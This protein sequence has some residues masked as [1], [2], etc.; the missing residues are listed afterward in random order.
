MKAFYEDYSSLGQFSHTDLAYI[1]HDPKL[2]EFFAYKPSKESISEA[3]EMRKKFAADRGLLLKVLK[4]QY[5]NLQLQLPVK[6]DVILNENTFTVVTSHQPT[7]LTGAL[8]HIYK[9]ASVIHLCQNLNKENPGQK[10]LPVFIMSGE[11]HDWPEVNHFHL[12]GRRY[13]WNRNASGPCGRLSLEGLNEVIESV[14]ELFNNV[15]FAEEIKTKLSESLTKAKNYGEF[16]SL[17]VASLFAEF[18]LIVLNLDDKELKEAFIP[19]FEKEIKE[20]FSHHHVTKTQSR[21]EQKGFKIQAF[22]RPVNMFY[23]TDEVRERLDPIEDGLIRVGSGV[24]YT[25]DEIITELHAHPERFSPNVILRPLYQ[26]FILPNIAYVGGG[27][28][29]AYW[30][31]RKDQ[32]SEA[33][34]HYPILIRRNSLLTID[35]ATKNQLNKLGLESKDM[36]ANLDVINRNFL[37]KHSKN[38]LTYETELKL[39]QDAYNELAAKAEKIDP[40]LSKAIMAEENKQI[41]LFEQ[42]GSRLERAEKQQQDTQIKKVQ[43]LKEKLFPENGL[44]ERHENFLSFYANEGPEWIKG[45]IE[46]CDPWIEKF[47]LVESVE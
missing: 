32:F 12:F 45:I 33:K 17:L 28:E 43:K 3:L 10:F 47:I 40:T 5:S 41:K 31:E 7:L 38:E 24:K 25:M 36:L 42:L 15:P 1:N 26:E 21:L 39:I 2:E 27:G 4:K 6:D 20:R 44:Q 29:L 23:M 30:L 13:E 14:S 46:I 34:V 11:D 19:I 22:C 18:G 9:I 8:F 37:H 35:A 16:H